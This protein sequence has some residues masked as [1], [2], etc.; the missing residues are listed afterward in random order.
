MKLTY[1]Q[2]AQIFESAAELVGKGWCQMEYAI[3]AENIVVEPESKEACKFCAIG[4]I[5]RAAHN[6]FG[7]KMLYKEGCDEANIQQVEDCLFSLHDVLGFEGWMKSV[8]VRKDIAK[9]N[10]T[11]C[12]KKEDVVATLLKARDRVLPEGA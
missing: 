8:G 11:M 10:D 1:N 4:A 5:R 3:N 7:G 2:Q 9:W 12:S 6:M